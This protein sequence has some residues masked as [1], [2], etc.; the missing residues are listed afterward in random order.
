MPTVLCP[1]CGGLYKAVGE[2]S[3]QDLSKDAVNALNHCR[4]CRTPSRDFL[5]IDDDQPSI[6]PDGQEFPEA[7]VSWIQ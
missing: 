5:L 2:S 3:L 4:L 6:G 1:K 7:I